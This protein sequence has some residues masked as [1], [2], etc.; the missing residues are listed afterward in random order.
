[1]ATPPS[2]IPKRSQKTTKSTPP[3]EIRSNP[4]IRR[5]IADTV[6]EGQK[7]HHMKGLLELDVTQAR[8]LIASIKKNTGAPFSFVAWLVFCVG[9]T[10]QQYP[11]AHCILR[12]NQI[13]LFQDV[14]ISII[15]ERIIDGEPFPLVYV[16]RNTERKTPTEINQEI[17]TAK[18]VDQDSYL[19]QSNNRYQKSTKTWTKLDFTK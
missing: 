4:K 19:D 6:E 18:N 7:R 12:G 14:D 17:Q 10:V 16:I 9:T 2:I 13:F 11:E 5:I 3:V 8:T 1:M 15:V